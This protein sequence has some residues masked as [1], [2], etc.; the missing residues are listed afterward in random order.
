MLRYFAST[1]VLKKVG[2]NNISRPMTNSLDLARL[3]ANLIIKNAQHEKDQPEPSRPHRHG[4][5]LDYGT[6]HQGRYCS[7][8]YVTTQTQTR[9]LPLTHHL[10]H[11]CQAQLPQR[12][13]IISLENDVISISINKVFLFKGAAPFMIAKPFPQY[14][15]PARSLR[16]I[17]H[18]QT[19][20]S[21]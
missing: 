16:L 15:T 18:R 7:Q 13:K 14:R 5:W 10:I 20:F 6:R 8:L 17:S 3:N 2:P 11:A 12:R 9:I 19:S 21:A 4:C 1:H